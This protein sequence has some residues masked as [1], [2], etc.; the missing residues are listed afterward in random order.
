ME[1]T[2]DAAARRFQ[3]TGG[4]EAYL[5]YETPGDGVLDLTHTY[6]AP[7]ERDKGVGEALVEHAL[8]YARDRE[9]L[10]IPTCPFVRKWISE[11]PAYESLV[12]DYGF[13]TAAKP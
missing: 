7:A 3:A 13:G 8:D 6:V 2:H 1:I 9:Y 12:T 5:A 11:H 4:T 10:V